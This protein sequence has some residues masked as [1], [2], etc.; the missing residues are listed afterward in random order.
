MKYV[1][2]IAFFALILI[3]VAHAHAESEVVKKSGA[4]DLR[5]FANFDARMESLES[6]RVE[7]VAADGK[8]DM[9]KSTPARRGKK[10][11]LSLEVR[12][13]KS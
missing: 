5:A 7:Y 9:M 6:Y 11:G 1:W 4:S 2:R 10:D 12:K 8:K 3:P 13:R